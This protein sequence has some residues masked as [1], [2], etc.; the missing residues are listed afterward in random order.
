MLMAFLRKKFIARVLMFGVAVIFIIASVFIYS[1]FKSGSLFS[2][3]KI[4]LKVNGYKIT[5]Q[6]YQ[7]ALRNK[8]DQMR[9][10]YGENFASM[11]RNIDFEE[12]TTD[13]LVQLALLRQQIDDFKMNVTNQEFS[14]AII[15][16]PD[17][18]RMYQIY[19]S[20]GRADG[21]REDFKQ[22]RGIQRFYKILTDIAIV[23]DA[24]I[25][26]EYRRQNEKAKLKYIEFSNRD[27]E[28]QVSVT[29][30]QIAE[31]YEKH[32]EKY[33]KGDQV[34]IKY[35]KI[36]PTKLEKTIS[37][38]DSEI[39]NYYTRNKENEFTEEEEVKASHILFKV[40]SDASEEEKDKVKAKAE[41][42]LEEAKKPDADFA[43]L[44]GE[45]S[46]DEGS[47]K[48][49]GDLGFFKR[50]RMV[51]EFEEA[52]F[53]L[54][55]GKISDLVESQYGYHIIKVEE[56]KE[57]DVKPL[58]EVR[59]EIQKKLAKEEAIS[60][61]KEM[62]DELLFDVTVEGMKAAAEN[63][64]YKELSL[65]VGET[66]FFSKD[67]DQIPTK[68][69]NKPDLGSRWEHRDLVDKVF[70]LQKGH[71]S[72]VIEISSYSGEPKAYFIAK[73]IDQKLAH[74]PVIDDIKDEVSN[75][76]K[77]EE[78]K[79]L[80]FKAA[81]SLMN[82]RSGSEYLEELSKK[83]KPAEEKTPK[84]LTVKET[85]L[86]AIS[87]SGYVSGMGT[88]KDTMLAAFSMKQDAVKGPF[89]GRN[90]SYIIQLVE[91]Q[92]FDL[93]KFQEDEEERIKIRGNLLQQKK[94]QIFQTWYEGIKEQA[95]IV[96]ERKSASL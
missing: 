15:E 6:E 49:G 73:V 77:D 20:M 16:E 57:E 56:K 45:Y 95:E 86:F 41:E 47:A 21:Y 72:D 22:R 96:V 3:A 13:E 80:A 71:T 88:S 93:Q 12:Q 5:Q 33:R 70:E 42:V 84:E 36:D 62:A 82:Q 1:G 38:S 8:I 58:D 24:E 14:K 25:E 92:D 68:D 79:K 34:D 46:E 69:E 29:D 64:K 50:G 2:K 23:T 76:I 28:D 54:E 89:D 31:Y 37:I 19:N 18:L 94:N 43:A 52:A 67:D 30:E 10:Q 61:A 81:Q 51:P 83:Y 75:D 85:Q 55:S 26:Q 39:N 66:G 63:P 90:G 27:F 35:L 53:N 65:E 78:A 87:T 40:E 11:S 74:I 4:A 91:R 7:N 9:R 44:A 59:S 17:D 48:K 32:K 60:E